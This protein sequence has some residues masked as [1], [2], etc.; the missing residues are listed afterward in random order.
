MLLSPDGHFI[1]YLSHYNRE[2]S[3]FT[4]Q[5]AAFEGFHYSLIQ[6]INALCHS[7]ARFQQ[8]QF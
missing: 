4:A 1:Q 2:P 6:N 3:F 5:T 7:T 8:I